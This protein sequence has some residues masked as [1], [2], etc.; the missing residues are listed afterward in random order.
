MTGSDAVWLDEA[1]NEEDLV[2]VVG[3]DIANPDSSTGARDGRIT[4]PK[5]LFEGVLPKQLAHVVP[6][7]ERCAD[8]SGADRIASPGAESP[9]KGRGESG[10]CGAQ[11]EVAAGKDGVD[12]N[13]FNR[14][15]FLVGLIAIQPFLQFRAVGE[16]GAFTTSAG[17]SPY[18]E[19]AVGG[20][21]LGGAVVA[22]QELC[23][24]APSYQALW[25]SGHLQSHNNTVQDFR[26]PDLRGEGGDMDRGG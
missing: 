17:D 12:M 9:N 15:R 18:G 14:K 1:S 26:E 7:A 4:I 19:P 22:I 25:L 16:D 10:T 3:E 13:G 21:A 23:D 24:L 2:G 20:P 6:G 5:T 8:K 11:E